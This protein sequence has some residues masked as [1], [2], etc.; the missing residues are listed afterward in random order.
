LAYHT[1]LEVADTFVGERVLLRALQTQDAEALFAA[2]TESRDHFYPWYPS[3]HR[4]Y[5]DIAEIC[6]Q[7][8]RWQARRLLREAFMQ[9]IFQ[10]VDGNFL[11][12]LGFRMANWES[13]S[14]DLTY[15]LRQSAEGYGY[16]TEAMRLIIGY[17]FSNLEAQRVEIRC[18]ERNQR[19]AAIARK[20]NFRQEGCLRNAGMAADGVME[21]TLI[22]SLIPSDL[23]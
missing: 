12:C 19:S 14:F 13:R 17:L 21:N 8:V 20:L 3:L 4:K 15:W 9:G 2:I 7:I 22:F 1:A 6:D 5:K 11:G 23:H 18:D 10:R 16:M